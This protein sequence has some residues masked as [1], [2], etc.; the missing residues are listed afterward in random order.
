MN[1]RHAIAAALIAG[2]SLFGFAGAANAGGTRP[3]P[4]ST[5]RSP[6][7][8]TAT[9]P[10]PVT[11]ATR[12]PQA[13]RRPSDFTDVPRDEVEST[14]GELVVD[15]PATAL[16]VGLLVGLL[17]PGAGLIGLTDDGEVQTREHILLARQVGVPT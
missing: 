13:G 7:P 11:P 10:V 17:L 14:R 4:M 15:R 16:L 5:T 6:C 3:A 12:G 1:T 9:L 2:T 8:S